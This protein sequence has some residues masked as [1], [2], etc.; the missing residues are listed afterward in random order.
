VAESGGATRV[1][2]LTGGAGYGEREQT[3]GREVVWEVVGDGVG[4]IVCSEGLFIGRS[5]LERGVQKVAGAGVW[6]CATGKAGRGGLGSV[7]AG[8]GLGVRALW[9][10]SY[11]LTPVGSWQGGKGARRG[12]PAI[13]SLSSMSHDP[14]WGRGGWGSTE[15]KS[16]GMATGL[17]RTNSASSTVILIS[18]RFAHQV[19]GQ[20]PA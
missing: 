17:G 14:G 3:G 15:G 9:A 6:R 10:C 20:M 16:M 5:G 4:A 18:M 11:E 8:F 19:L 7:L 13:S 2:E 1:Q 12:G